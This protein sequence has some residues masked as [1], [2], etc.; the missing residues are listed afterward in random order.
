ML[1][2]VAPEATR[3]TGAFTFYVLPSMSTIAPLR[4]GDMATGRDII[5]YRSVNYRVSSTEEWGDDYLFVY[6]VRMDVQEPIPEGIPVAIT[7]GDDAVLSDG[8]QA[9]S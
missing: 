1:A 6:A 9:I 7:S 5:T 4:T 8:Q 3:V 2:R